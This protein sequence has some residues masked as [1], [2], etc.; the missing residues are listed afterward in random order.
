MS[1]LW[2][3]DRLPNLDWKPGVAWLMALAGTAPL[4]WT[5][6]AMEHFIWHLGYGAAAGLLAAAL[7]SWVRKS[8]PRG[9]S[10]WA[11]AG[12]L[13]MIIPDGIWLAPVLLGGDPIEHAPWM[14]IFLGH[15]ALD[16]WRYTSLFLVPVLLLG[17]LTVGLARRRAHRMGAT[18]KGTM[19]HGSPAPA[20]EGGPDGP[21]G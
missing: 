7:F 14:N 5:E 10:W 13:Y 1:R 11:L 12:Y 6:K 3:R 20:H 16:E 2:S 19:N 18:V 15:P 8:P 17:L 4:Y 21:S 9:A